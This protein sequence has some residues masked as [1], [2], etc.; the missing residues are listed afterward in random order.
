LKVSG[1]LKLRN[2]KIK[3]FS[4][5]LNNLVQGKISEVT[6]NGDLNNI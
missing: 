5:E 4:K 1:E 3:E 2:H 6:L